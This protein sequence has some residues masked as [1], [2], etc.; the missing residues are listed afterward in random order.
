MIIIS[1]HNVQIIIMVI[2]YLP[3]GMLL[4]LLNITNTTI[5]ELE[6]NKTNPNGWRLNEPF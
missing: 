4:E 3:N 1:L 2:N 5:I 6:S